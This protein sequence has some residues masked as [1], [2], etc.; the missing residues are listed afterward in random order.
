MDIAICDDDINISNAIYHDITNISDISISKIDI[1]TTAEALLFS[2]DS[3]NY[4]LIFMDTCI[5]ETSGIKTAE[6]LN[7]SQ[8][9][10]QIIF[11]SS[12]DDYYLDVYNV[13]HI[14]FLKAPIDP[15]KLKKALMVASKKI[16]QYKSEHFI[17]S[18]KEGTF[19]IPLNDIP[20]LEKHRRLIRIHT[21]GNITHVIYGKF[22]DIMGSF[23]SCFH[24]CHTSYVVNFDHVSSMYRSSFILFDGTEVPISK[25]YASEVKN[26]FLD[27]LEVTD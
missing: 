11:M 14:Y 16:F 22:S 1:F 19:R 4:D 5:G 2:A 3:N 6:K 23:D 8:P 7:L 18:N 24:Q 13:E 10:A 27:Y 21:T 12:Y 9:Q 26:A 17:V 15:N 25:K 20:L